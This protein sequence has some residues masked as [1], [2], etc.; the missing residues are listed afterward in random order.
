MSGSRSTAPYMLSHLALWLTSFSQGASPEACAPRG[1][2]LRDCPR[3]LSLVRQHRRRPC[4]QS[5]QSVLFRA[6]CC[7]VREEKRRD[8]VTS[9]GFRF[10]TLDAPPS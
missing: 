3:L 6:R 10:A 7:V 5:A 4:R 2:S 9:H 1:G 8:H